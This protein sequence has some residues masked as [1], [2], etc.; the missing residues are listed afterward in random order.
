VNGVAEKLHALADEL[1]AGGESVLAARTEELAAALDRATYEELRDTKDVNEF[2]D[3]RKN[4]ALA[5]AIKRHR[6]RQA[7]G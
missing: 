5:A 7:K 4:P 1:R 2:N 6:E 3:A